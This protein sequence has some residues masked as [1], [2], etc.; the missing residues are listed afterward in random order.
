MCVCVWLQVCS[1]Y[2]GKQRDWIGD[3]Q[4]VGISR[5]FC[6]A[7][8]KKW[9]EGFWSCWETQK[10]WSFWL[11][12]VSSA[13]CDGFSKHWIPC[14][15]YQVPD[16]KAWYLGMIRDWFLEVGFPFFPFFP[17]PFSFP[18]LVFSWFLFLWNC[19]FWIMFFFTLNFTR[20]DL[21]Y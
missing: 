6:G 14:W 5:C 9:K 4:A 11:H 16:W 7:D 3:M 20:I 15:V 1:C 18:S 12:S 17:S 21:Y 13:R 10:I 2:R 8:C 19:P